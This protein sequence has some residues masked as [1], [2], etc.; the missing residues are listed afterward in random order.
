MATTIEIKTYYSED[1]RKDMLELSDERVLWK[2]TGH[3]DEEF[4]SILVA[5]ELRRFMV[6][7]GTPVYALGRS[8]RHICVDDTNVNRKWYRRMAEWVEDAQKELVE[9]WNSGAW[10]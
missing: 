6:Q 2:I 7:F 10:N 8:G 1:Y 4:W 5:S 3:F 9:N